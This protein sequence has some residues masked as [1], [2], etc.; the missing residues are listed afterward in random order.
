MIEGEERLPMS[1]ME[2]ISD[3]PC[4]PYAFLRYAIENVRGRMEYWQSLAP[5]GQWWTTIEGEKT[6]TIGNVVANL[7]YALH[8]LDEAEEKFKR[9]PERLEQRRLRDEALLLG[10]IDPPVGN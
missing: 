1:I 7:Q 10:A 9:W 4:E 5:D 6:A 8:F 2:R 3:A